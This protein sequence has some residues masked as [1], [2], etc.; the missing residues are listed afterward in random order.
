MLYI[1]LPDAGEIEKVL[2]AIEMRGLS[3]HMNDSKWRT[4]CTAIAELPF[5]PAYQVKLVL[6][7]TPD[8]EKFAESPSYYGDWATTPEASMGIFV[9]WL[10]VA[11]RHSVRLGQLSAPGVG[12]CSEE[13]RKLLKRLHIPFN[14]KDGFFYIYGHTSSPEIFE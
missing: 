6:S 5:P 11:P 2:R 9:E 14:R 8:P 12:D 13:L 7:D 1:G 3:S 4:L 10:K